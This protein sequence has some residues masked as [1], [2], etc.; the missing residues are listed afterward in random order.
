MGTMDRTNK[1]SPNNATIVHYGKDKIPPVPKEVE[2]Q[3]QDIVKIQV[4]SGPSTKD[5]PMLLYNSNRYYQTF[6]HPGMNG[7]KEI[8]NMIICN[9]G[10]GA[11]GSSGGTKGYFFCL[12]NSTT[13]DGDD[14]EGRFIHV[15]VSKMAPNQSW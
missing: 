6:I 1:A 13:A 12:S 8:K 9:G 11:L 14:D 7:Y 15:N 5:T 2:E 10:K 3:K 4:A